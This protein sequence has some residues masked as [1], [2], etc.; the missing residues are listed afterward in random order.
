MKGPF[1]VLSTAVQIVAFAAWAFG[2][3]S[4]FWAI[5]W[6]VAV[7]AVNFIVFMLQVEQRRRAIAAATTV[8]QTQRAPKGRMANVEANR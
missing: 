2:Q 4:G 8:E 5:E 7:Y 1:Q 3:R 6:V